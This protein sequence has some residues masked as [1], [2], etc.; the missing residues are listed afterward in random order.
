[1]PMD[2]WSPFLM[3]GNILVPASSWCQQI[4]GTSQSLVS[5]KFWY[6]P[7]PGA[8]VILVAARFWCQSISGGSPFLV[9]VHSGA[10]GSGV[11]KTLASHRCKL[12]F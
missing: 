2:F 9:P 8:S 5:A 10:C 11:S 7:F 1:M 6:Q 3:P 12:I 4:P